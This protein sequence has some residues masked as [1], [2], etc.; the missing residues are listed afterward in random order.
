MFYNQAILGKRRSTV[1]FSA[2]FRHWHRRSGTCTDDRR[3]SC[4]SIPLRE[5]TQKACLFYDGQLRL[6]R[7]V[8]QHGVQSFEL[9]CSN[10]LN[11][12]TSINRCWKSRWRVS[13]HLTRSL[14]SCTFAFIL[15]RHDYSSNR[16]ENLNFYIQQNIN[17]ALQPCS[18][19]DTSLFSCLGRFTSE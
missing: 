9:S 18:M 13:R 10:F 5:E 16:C 1:H 4:H 7:P 15:S 3:C 6:L 14:W 17:N 11:L 8:H 12:I 2:W 19:Y